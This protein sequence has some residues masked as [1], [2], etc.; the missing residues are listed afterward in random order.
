M[1]EALPY[2]LTEDPLEAFLSHFSFDEYDVDHSITEVNTL[3]VEV[4]MMDFPLWRA[5]FK[6]LPPL[7]KIPAPPSIEVPPKLELK[8]LPS[9]LKYVYLGP[10][11]TLPVIV[12]SDLSDDQEGQL[13][14]V[15]KEHK[16]AIG[17]SVVDLKGIEP[18]ICMH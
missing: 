11:E 18:S 1:E 16:S 6:H 15:L 7:S 9:T 2:I 5:K 10:K 3:L 4:A 12:T 17:W 14:D 8:P 13:L